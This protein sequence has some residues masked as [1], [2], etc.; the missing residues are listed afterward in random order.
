[1]PGR[2][3]SIPEAL[4]HPGRNF[5][6]RRRVIGGLGGPAFLATAPY[7][8][9]LRSGAGCKRATKATRKNTGTPIAAAPKKK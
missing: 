7:A 2:D 3:A 9:I 4:K 5:A 8:L 6:R 1:M